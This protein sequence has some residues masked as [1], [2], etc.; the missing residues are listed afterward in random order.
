MIKIRKLGDM[1]TPYDVA[2]ALI[3]ATVQRKN[4]TGNMYEDDAFTVDELRRIG[5]H[6]IAFAQI[7]GDQDE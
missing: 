1:S 5:E 6:L 3:N 2:D 4:I 7:E